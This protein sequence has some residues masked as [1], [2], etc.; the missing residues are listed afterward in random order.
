MSRYVVAIDQGT[1]GTTVLVLDEPLGARAR[2]YREFPQHLPEA[3]LGRARSRG[4]L[5]VG[6]GGA[7]ATRCMRRRSRRARRVARHRHHQ[8]ARDDAV[9]WERATGKPLHN[10][11]VWQ[12][13]RTADAV[14]ALKAAGHEPRDPRDDRPRARSRT[15]PAPSCVA[16][17]QRDRRCARAPR[18]ARS[19]SAPSTASSCGGLTGGAAHVDRRH[20]R[21]AHAALRPAHARVGRRAA[22]RSS[23]C[24]A[25]CCPTV[26]GSSERLRRH[27]RR[28]RP[29][30]TASRS[31]ASPAISR[32]RCSARP[33]SPSATPSAPTAP[34]RSC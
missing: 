13:R 10:A 29:A 11:I 21:L 23:T 6:H 18:R 31:P 4:D 15:S 8:P 25:R 17:R 27:A 14:R 5:G 20:Q 24:R 33:A 19:A 12:D 30:A 9:L 3:G 2:G 1:T 28:A 32:R 34:A 7:R 22:A 16:A 26:R